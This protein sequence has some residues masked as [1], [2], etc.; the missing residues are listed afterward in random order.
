MA[1]LF[2]REN[3][4][5]LEGTRLLIVFMCN[6][7]SFLA[8]KSTINAD[9]EWPEQILPRPAEESPCEPGLLGKRADTSGPPHLSCKRHLL[10]PLLP[11]SPNASAASPASWW[12]VWV[13]PGAERVLRGITN[14]ES[15]TQP[16]TSPAP[17]CYDPQNCVSLRPLTSFQ[18]T[19]SCVPSLVPGR[20]MYWREQSRPKY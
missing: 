8:G 10:H 12:W 19:W 16:L 17:K 1:C 6:D 7:R 18:I 5:L 20:E 13:N 3:L 15:L 14:C 4:N 11:S 9:Y 2:P